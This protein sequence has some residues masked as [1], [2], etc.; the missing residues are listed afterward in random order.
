MAPERITA[1]IPTYNSE[2]YIR[3]AV[4]S[5]LGQTYPIHEVLV[6]DDGSTDRTQ[7]LLARYGDRISYISQPNAGPPAAR[8]RGLALATGDLIALLDSDDLWAP[9]KTERQMDYFKRHPECGLVYSDMKT[10]DDT[11]II[12]ESVK[13]S[14]HLQLPSGWVFAELFSETLF[15]TS[16]VL[17]RKKC[18]DTIGGFD[19]CLR[20]GDDYELFLRVARHFELGYVDEPLVFYRQHV[21]QGTRSWGKQLQEGLPWEFIVLNSVL[22]RYP[23][24]IEELGRGKVHRR[25]SKPFATLAYACMAEGDHENCRRL[26][27][28]ALHYCPINLA[29]LRYYV[30]TF[31]SPRTLAGV[32]HLSAMSRRFMGKHAGD[33]SASRWHSAGNSGL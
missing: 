11:G 22:R 32:K 30:M 8:N 27:R 16:A 2:R 9:T 33:P 29:Y 20:M 28:S 17:V 14:R 10:F 19:T 12:E 15:Q 24:V 6:I 1:L 3:E 25:L 26:I 31:L 4:E 21:S 7:D 5:V 18:L 13:I 23:E